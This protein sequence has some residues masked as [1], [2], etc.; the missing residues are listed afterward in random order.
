LLVVALANY[1][2]VLWRR[3]YNWILSVY[4]Y[5]KLIHSIYQIIVPTIQWATYCERSEL[6]HCTYFIEFFPMI[7]YIAVIPIDLYLIYMVYSLKLLIYNDL[8]DKNGRYINV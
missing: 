5:S 1:I 6:E 7:I 8:I 4:L 2:F 3:S